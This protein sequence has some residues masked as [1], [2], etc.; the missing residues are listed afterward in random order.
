MTLAMLCLRDD[1]FDI[2]QDTVTRYGEEPYCFSFKPTVLPHVQAAIASRGP[3]IIGD[4]VQHR[5]GR[6][7]IGAA[8]I[9]SVLDVIAR[10]ANDHVARL[11]AEGRR[12]DQLGF[13]LYVA[14]WSPSRNRF[15]GWYMGSEAPQ[16]VELKPG[17]YFKPGGTD[18]PP[19]WEPNLPENVSAA[20]AIRAVADIKRAMSAGG[21][22][23]YG[24]EAWVVAVKPMGI[25]IRRAFEFEDNAALR[26]GMEAL[27]GHA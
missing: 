26:A 10:T 1:G 6:T 22:D 4:L 20:V 25:T 9:E 14:G 23:I 8:G 18:T 13:D 3:T 21:E 24:G 19:S 5:L 17:V 12:D 27:H 7:F 16:P 11:R 15:A 2:V